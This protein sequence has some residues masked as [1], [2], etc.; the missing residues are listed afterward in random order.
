LVN[1]KLNTSDIINGISAGLSIIDTNFRV[2]WVN[3]IQADWFG[4]SKDICGK[5]CYQAY[6]GTDEICKN[7]PT[8][9][10]FETGKMQIGT[11]IAIDKFGNPRHYSLTVTPVKDKNNKIRYAV[12]LVQD[13][14]EKVEDEKKRSKITHSLK[15]MYKH[16]SCANK[17]LYTSI[18]RLKVLT[19]N[20]LHTNHVIEKKYQK[21]KNKLF[22]I[23]EELEGILKVNRT[24]SSEDD[25]ART[26]YL[27]TKSICE[28]MNT[29]SCVLSLLDEEE[30]FLAVNSV[31]GLKEP[32]MKALPKIRMG[33]GI[34]G[35]VAM[36]RKPFASSDMF[37]DKRIRFRDT[38]VMNTY[39]SLAKQAGIRSVLVVPVVLHN[40]VLGV[41]ST[42]SNKKRY[43]KDEEIE[44]LMLFASQVAIAVEETKHR[45]DIHRNYFNTMHALVLAIEARDPYT[46]G[47]TERVTKYSVE[48]AKAT[49][50]SEKDIEILRFA[51]EVHDVGKISI[52]DFILNKPGKLTHGERAMIELHPVKGAQMLE[53]LD[54]LKPAIPI[55]RHH[56]ERYD[57][58]GYPDGLEKEKI[59]LFARIIA[60]ADSFDA[61]TSERP[62]RRNK[63]TTEE[64]IMEIKNNSGSQ[65]DPQIA[66][67]F[68]RLIRSSSV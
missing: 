27:I 60:C 19:G 54:F 36:T 40:K 59:P 2:V 64:A 6:K 18:K 51:S 44:I 53:P 39:F 33:D 37:S 7:C 15:R 34:S 9:K 25:S 61:M 67:V 1:G 26:S 31:Y 52:P 28:L 5:K 11:N 8:Q 50:M 14:T 46:R 66:Q 21:S 56:H 10:V 35:S 16:L 68:I 41:I 45:E 63:L 12:E 42:Y 30:K 3:K 4:S 43:F 55:V 49:K 29:D 13:V 32:V 58:T 48:F 24:L 38:I 17:K 65:F 62:Y 20:V 22:T 57:G 47:H 23:K